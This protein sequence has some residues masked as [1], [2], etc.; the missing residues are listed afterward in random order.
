MNTKMISS[1]IVLN[2]GFKLGEIVREVE[3]V[4]ETAPKRSR[5]RIHIELFRVYEGLRY[6]LDELKVLN[7][8][9][10]VQFE[11][12]SYLDQLSGRKLSKESIN[13]EKRLLTKVKEKLRER[14]FSSKLKIEEVK[15]LQLKLKIWRDRIS[16][17]LGRLGGKN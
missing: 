16:G 17:D 8:S 2:I 3:L 5:E 13:D 15:E 7:C 11:I 1:E 10:E 9:S 6:V 14:S 4:I 12:E